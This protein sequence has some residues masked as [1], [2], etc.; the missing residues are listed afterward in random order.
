MKQDIVD[1][2]FRLYYNEALLYTLSICHDIHEA[3]DIVSTAFFKALETADGTINEFKPWLL[4]VCR[5][6]FLQNCRKR[7]HISDEEIDPNVPDEVLSAV[8]RIIKQEEYR[9]LYKA[10]DSLQPAAREVLELFYFSGMKV[11]QISEIT[12]MSE[13]SVKTSLSRSRA[14]LKQLL[15]VNAE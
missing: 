12:G 11:K 7:K 13:A 1:K 15:E 3:E 14:H 2:L 9:M 4:A 8:D 6:E 5:N 10:M